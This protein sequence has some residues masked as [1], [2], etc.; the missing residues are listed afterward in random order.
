MM[1]LVLH[2]QVFENA[3]FAFE[4]PPPLW[5]HIASTMVLVAFSVIVS[6]TTDCL[7]IVLELNVS[8]PDTEL[9]YM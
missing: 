4:Q 9:V 5:R 8:K 7:G 1:S 2:F 6:M 3:I